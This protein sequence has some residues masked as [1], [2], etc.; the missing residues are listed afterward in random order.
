MPAVQGWLYKE[1]ICQILMAPIYPH[2][3]PG[4]NENMTCVGGNKF[5][6]QK[7]HTEWGAMI[8]SCSP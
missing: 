3:G 1:L 2:C 5:I 8:K 7:S 4:N 6:C